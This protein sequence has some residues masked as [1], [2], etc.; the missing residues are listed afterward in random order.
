M[1]I[2]LTSDLHLGHNKDFVVDARGFDTIEEHDATIIDNWNK[3]IQS[4][5]EVYCLGDVMLDDIDSGIEKLKLLNGHIHIV[6]G[7][8]DTDEKIKR[9]AECP[10]VEEIVDAKYLRSG[11]K[12]FYL[13]HYPTIVSHEKLKKFKH[14]LINLYGH[15]HQ[16]DN[17]YMLDGSA[18]PYMYHVGVD[19]HN[20]MPVLLEEIIEEIKNKKDEY[21]ET[22]SSEMIGENTNNHEEWFQVWEEQANELQAIGTPVFETHAHYDL[23]SYRTIRSQMMEILRKAGIDRILIPSIDY[24]SIS[25]MKKLFDSEEY[26]YVYYSFGCHPKHLF[27]NQS[28]WTK[29][30]LDTFK[31]TIRN[32]PK[33]IA[34][35]ETGLDFSIEGVSADII[36]LQKDY[37]RKFIDLGNSEG[38]P[39]ILHIRHSDNP[40]AC[41]VDVDDEA[42]SILTKNPIRNGAVLHCF[43]GS[44]EDARSYLR[45]GV[46]HFGIGGRVCDGNPVLEDAVS[47]MPEESIILETDSPFIRLKG[48]PGPNTSLALFTIAKKV[49]ELRGTD[50]K[51]VFEVSNS[52]ARKLFFKIS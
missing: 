52:N 25:G 2:F 34:I 41:G 47:K 20:L 23:S 22:F 44:I 21:D 8:H 43:G 42:I 19:S 17:F 4:D 5:D 12:T 51:H 11:K 46:T 32:E 13:S 31:D 45:T 35:G 49:A 24:S 7:N 29:E 38:L 1:S 3:R 10:N 14:A 50:I 40:D 33:C 16:N 28:I 18:H 6:R 39:L 27:E 26:N 37:F 15:T 36:E 9:Y 48:V 30:I